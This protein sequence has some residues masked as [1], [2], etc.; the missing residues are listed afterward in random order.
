MYIVWA[1]AIVVFGVL[2]GITTQLVSIWFV[3]GAIAALIASLC[4]ATLPVQVIIFVA[5]T[6]I[7]LIATRP[8]VKKRINTTFEKTNADR[9]I[10]NEAVVCEE[11]DNL[12]AKGQVKTGG[13]IWSARSSDG[14]VI[15]ENT[16]VTVEKIDGVKLIVK[17]GN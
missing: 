11:I 8:I 5:V 12:K 16:V 17:I 3:L 6:V 15:P 1:I 10:G 4:S 14:S 9:C 13:Q 7:A 2:E